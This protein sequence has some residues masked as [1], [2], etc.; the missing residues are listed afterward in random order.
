MPLFLRPGRAGYPPRHLF[1]DR[2]PRR[3]GYRDRIEAGAQPG[4]RI[5]GPMVWECIFTVLG[6]LQR[7]DGEALA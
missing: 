3:Q 6:E 4:C 5:R 1:G 7:Q 2:Q